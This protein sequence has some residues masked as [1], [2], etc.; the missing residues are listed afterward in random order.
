MNRL[1]AILAFAAAIV[2]FPA[3]ATPAEDLA[4]L[5]DDYWSYQLSQSPT[6]ATSLG[7]RDYDDQIGD[8]S[9]AAMDARAAKTAEFLRRLEEI[10]LDSLSEEQRVTAQILRWELESEVKSNTF[11]QRTMLFTTYYGW[12]QGFA[13]MADNLPFENEADYRSYLT[14]M[15]L[16]PQYNDA[17][18][19][20]SDRAI[21]NGYVLPCV[22]LDDFATSIVGVIAEDPTQSRYYE[23]FLEAKPVDMTEAE[24]SAMQAEAREII[25]ERINP[26]YRKH[27]EWFR[28]DY[29]PNCAEQAGISAQPGGSE[30]Y[31]FQVREMTTTG[32]TPDQI[33]R[34]G[35][36]EVARIRT[37]ME[38]VAREAGYSSR[39]AFI[40]HLRTD[41]RYYAETPEELL[42]VA[43]RQAKLHDG[44][45]PQYFGLLPRLPYGLKKIPAETAEGTT[46]AY[47]SPGSPA[48]GVAGFYYVNTS[49]LDQ[50]PLYELPALT[51]H[52]AVPGHH[53]QIAINQ[54]LDLPD[55]RRAGASFTAFTEGWGLYSEF[56]GIEMGIYDTPAKDMGRLSYEMWRACRLVVDTGIHSKGWTKAQAVE[57]MQDNTALSEANIDAEVNRY[58]SWPGQAL[59]YKIG[60]LKIRELRDRAETALGEDFVLRDFHDTVLENG[61]VPLEVLETHVERWIN[62]QQGQ[63]AT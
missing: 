61:S 60:E 16:Y 14:R 58:I 50:R 54:E 27:A 4:E 51:A 53:H 21:E 37:Q 10:P 52:E 31:A 45:M 25:S 56:L 44:M 5:T 40:E 19:A 59:G 62:A 34:I 2:S 48:I 33:H 26:A 43:A 11:G 3:W 46:T 23:P 57:F 47:Y 7:V 22:V 9:L 28:E 17:A 55:F 29:L 38:E 8:P 1:F 42:E 6:Y 49:L 30:Y 35:L 18:L 20:L 24:W 15:A 39:E 41:P 36:E 13:G 12:H 32:L 63:A